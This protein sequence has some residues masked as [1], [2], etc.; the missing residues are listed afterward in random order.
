LTPKDK[1]P[2]QLQKK[3]TTST[4]LYPQPEKIK[5]HQKRL[6]AANRGKLSQI[7]HTK[8]TPTTTI[9]LTP[10]DKPPHQLQKKNTTSAPLY[11]QPKKIKKHQKRLLAANKGKLSKIIHTKLTPTTTINLTPKDKPPHQLQKKVTTCKDPIT[12]D[13]NTK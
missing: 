5:K 9:N 1:P 8:L 3:N 6:L 13:I 7:I 10:K 2:H 11:P 12:I 4:P